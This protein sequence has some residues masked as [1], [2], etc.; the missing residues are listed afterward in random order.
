M[1]K[2]RVPC[3]ILAVAGL[4]GSRPAAARGADTA[5]QAKAMIEA[6]KRVNSR[7][8]GHVHRACERGRQGGG[9]PRAGPAWNARL[10]HPRKGRLLG[11]RRDVS[12]RPLQPCGQPARGTDGRYAS[13]RRPRQHRDRQDGKGHLEIVDDLVT[14]KPDPTSVVGKSVIFHEKVDDL[15]TQPAGNSGARLGCGVIQ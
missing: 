2:V 13:Q 14:V 6:K 4:P 8:N 7:R 15:K 11:A 9:P 10:P 3:T 5:A 12:R 1:E